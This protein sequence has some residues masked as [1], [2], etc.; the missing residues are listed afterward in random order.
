MTARVGV[1]GLLGSGNLGNDGSLEA[2]LGYLR[3][4]HPDATVSAFCGGP[5]VVSARY[6]IEATR[7]NWY[8]DEYRTASSPRAVVLKALGKLID[9]GRTAAWVRRQDV[10]LVPGMGVLEATL[11]LRPWGFPYAL[12]LLSVAGRVL[13]TKVALVGVG[14]DRITVPAT[15]FLLRQAARLA[16]YRSYRDELSRTAMAEMGVAVP[17]D[18]VYPDLAFSLPVPAVPEDP[19]TVGVG[20]MAYSGSDDDRAEGDRIYRSYV[21]AMTRFV[22]HLVELGRP[23]RLFIGDRIDTEVTDEIRAAVASPLVTAAPSATLEE[24]MTEM[25]AVG[26]V[27]ATRYHNVLCALKLGKPTL[28]IG[29]ARKNDVLMAG[30]GL[31]GFCQQARAVDVARLITQFE[32]LERRGP[33]L[34]ETLAERNEENEQRLKHQFAALSASLFPASEVR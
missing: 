26:T 31:G 18:A 24:L 28:A 21:D 19:R 2:V 34:R 11:P 15:R 25:A 17:G 1:F 4:E 20:V 10:V 3:A 9:I 8:V 13:G 14:A 5:A 27:V 12:C 22:R 16:A 23:V 29:Y 6:G 7:L 32:E 30:M 33:Q